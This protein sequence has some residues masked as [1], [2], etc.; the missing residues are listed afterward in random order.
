MYSL[1]E[2][3]V[4]CSQEP[5]DSQEYVTENSRFAGEVNLPISTPISRNLVFGCFTLRTGIE[6]EEGDAPRFVTSSGNPSQILGLTRV[7]AEEF[8]V[9]GGF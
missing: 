1:G 7:K 5:R 2:E 6:F 4:Q 9:R 3:L 8:V